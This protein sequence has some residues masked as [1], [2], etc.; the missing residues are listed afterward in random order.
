M[1]VDF[2]IPGSFNTW[3]GCGYFHRSQKW[4][5]PFKPFLN[6]CP[7]R[8]TKFTRFNHQSNLHALSFIQY[9]PEYLGPNSQ[10]HIKYQLIANFFFE[11]FTYTINELHTG[12]E[13]ELAN[14][15]Q[16]QCTNGNS[17]AKET[18]KL[19]EWMGHSQS[20]KQWKHK[21]QITL[22]IDIIY[23]FVNESTISMY[24]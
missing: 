21:N 20:I 3:H 13:F 1:F 22:K 11:Q 12:I 8:N 9:S 7:S 2:W 23:I 15:N 14:S 18:Y 4:N 19:N 16:F 6:E 5:F 24:P 17:A 10:P